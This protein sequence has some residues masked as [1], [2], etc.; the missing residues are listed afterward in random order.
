[1]GPR[2]G[3]TGL[4]GILKPK[5]ITQ[6]DLQD[7]KYILEEREARKFEDFIKCALP[8]MDSFE[9]E[10]MYRMWPEVIERVKARTDANLDLHAQM[11][12]IRLRS[13][14]SKQDYELSYLVD[15]GKVKIDDKLIF[16][17][18]FNSLDANIRGEQR[19]N[20][21]TATPDVNDNFTPGFLRYPLKKLQ[22]RVK[23]ITDSSPWFWSRNDG[24][25]N[26]TIHVME[27]GMRSDRL[28]YTQPNTRLTG[29]L[30]Y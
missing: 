18:M 2:A 14:K 17:M 21:L 5:A 13:A 23:E 24:D 15:T 9:K 3:V 4:T 11:A 26:S 7:T 27:N 22:D 19:D 28:T 16:N 6:Q 8:D 20:T 10:K 25:T 30:F 1:L 29:A 12:K